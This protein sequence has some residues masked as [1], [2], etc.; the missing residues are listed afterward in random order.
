MKIAPA[1]ADRFCAAP[2]AGVRL[3]L[4]YGSNEGLVRAR[5]EACV[6][7][8]AEDPDDPFRVTSLDPAL[9]RG[10]PGRLADEAAA[11]SLTGGR[12]AVRLRGVTE[13][14]VPAVRSCLALPVVENLVVAEAGP[15]TPR[16][17][18]RRLCEQ[19]QSLAAIPCYDE[20]TEGARALIEAFCSQRN[21]SAAPETI[22]WLAERL[23]SD[24]RQIESEVEKL[25]VYLGDSGPEGG[26]LTMEVAEAC[27]GDA[28]EA[29]A[30]AVA[31]LAVSGDLER[32]D[33]A[34][35][36]ALYGGVQPIAMLRAAA[37]RLARLHLATGAVEGGASRGDAMG[38]LKPPVYPRERAAFAQEM[39]RW[40]SAR[41]GPRTGAAHRRGARLQGLRWRASGDLLAGAAS[42]R[43]GG[44]QG[45]RLRAA[46]EQLRPRC[47]P[48]CRYAATRP[49]TPDSPRGATDA[50]AACRS[51]PGLP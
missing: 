17:G 15:L 16:S 12:R 23:G 50:E 51:A 10:E 22:A 41:C 39:T 37:R 6:R 38:A 32:L 46:S 48:A 3:V 27:V 19:E 5:A 21:L 36:R 29:S 30:D 31:R 47:R 28:A 49:R 14:A 43:A 40:P 33:R 2:D 8:V 11:L 44:P 45:A 35:A 34:L 25:A 18:L 1:R 24:R 9:L 26:V 7:A 20:S 4:I 42:R 13:A